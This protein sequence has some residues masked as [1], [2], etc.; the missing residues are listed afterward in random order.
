MGSF[1]KRLGKIHTL[2]VE[3]CYKGKLVE[4]TYQNVEFQRKLEMSVRVV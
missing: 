3:D 4:A 2:L 1:R